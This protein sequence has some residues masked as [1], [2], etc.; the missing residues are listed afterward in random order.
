MAI[1]WGNWVGSSPK[2]FRIGIEYTSIP[3]PA[4]NSTTV[5]V[6]ARI[7]IGVEYSITDS[8]NSFSYSGTLGSGSGARSVSVASN[9]SQILQNLSTAVTLNGTGVATPLT[10]SASMSGIDYVGSGLTASHTATNAI[11]AKP[12]APVAAPGNVAS[13][14]A[15]R[16]DDNT[17]TITWPA[18]SGATS[19]VLA[20]YD[21][22]KPGD[23]YV[24]W[25]Y[26]TGT[27]YT[28]SSQTVNNAYE[29]R[30][31]AV[32]SGGQSGW[33]YSDSYTTTPKAPSNLTA[34]KSGNDIVVTIG[35][36]WSPH[37]EHWEWRESSNGGST[38]TVLGS[39]ANAVTSYTHVAPSAATSHVYQARATIPSEGLYSAWS[40][41][42]NVVTLSTPPNA[43]TLRS[44]VGITINKATNQVIFEWT[45]NPVDTTAQT[46]ANVDYRVVGSGSWT[47]VNVPSSAQTLTRSITFG[48]N[49]QYEW[50]VQTKG[51]NAAYGSYSAVAVFNVGSAPTVTLTSP[52][53]PARSARP[54]I[55]WT[56]SSPN[57]K[58]QAWADVS[59]LDS[60][61]AYLYT[62]RVSGD[63]TS[64]TP[65]HTLTDGLTYY[66]EVVA[67]DTQGLSGSTRVSRA[68]SFLPPPVQTL[69]ASWVNE[70]HGVHLVHTLVTGA[71]PVS[72]V[73]YERSFDTATWATLAQGIPA[74]AGLDS[75]FVDYV[76]PFNT[77][78][79]YRII[80]VSAQ[81]AESTSAEVSVYTETLDAVVNYG[82]GLQES[83]TITCDLQVPSS[84]VEHVTSYLFAGRA[85]P[86]N[87]YDLDHIP[88]RVVQVS[89]SVQAL[90]SCGLPVGTGSG[91]RVYESQL[92]Q[93]SRQDVLWRDY[94]GRIFKAKITGAA[95]TPN[96]GYPE[97]SFTVTES[98]G[99]V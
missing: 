96:Y 24:T 18:V 47:T 75:N 83:M 49:T 41:S 20:R 88:T 28:A 44:P 17:T 21:Y 9:G 73:R 60:T 72:T 39:T 57:G 23:G 67:Q 46:A 99:E 15:T 64:H 98:D 89:G 19:Y 68:V 85:K 48:A 54:P 25:S 38:W 36:D 7:W 16:V 97:V 91:F 79:Y 74:G 45:H 58:T 63:S 27:S 35:T 56:F 33:T 37:N 4:Y 62:V 40:A 12:A 59:I 2:R 3:T 43:P 70:D 87:V 86:V 55:T 51:A 93:M 26:P 10:I 61:Q 82:A 14:T 84:I 80:G 32:N 13:L 52:T 71:E 31:A 95:L 50:R 78:V 69:N 6:T 5:T 8:S 65:T 42:S 90:Q 34:T 76:A 29:W 1:S 66:F 92:I 77:M 11:P 53:A 30:I 22:S 81:G 94:L